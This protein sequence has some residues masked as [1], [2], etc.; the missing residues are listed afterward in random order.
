[1]TSER[2]QEITVAAEDVRCALEVA[3]MA[4]IRLQHLTSPSSVPVA[5][6]E[7]LGP[8]AGRVATVKVDAID[9]TELVSVFA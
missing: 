1:M 2:L 8:L 6:Y 4:V 3:S 5:L 9:Y 7:T